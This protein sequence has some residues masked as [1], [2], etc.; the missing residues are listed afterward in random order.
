MQARGDNSPGYAGLC[1]VLWIMPT[2]SQKREKVR[3]LLGFENESN[4]LT[5]LD[6]TACHRHAA[7]CTDPTCW[8]PA[9]KKQV[10]QGTQ[11]GSAPKKATQKG[12]WG[13]RFVPQSSAIFIGSR[14]SFAVQIRN[15]EGR[16]RRCLSTADAFK[17]GSVSAT[18]VDL[19]TCQP[20]EVHGAYTPV[21]RAQP[22]RQPIRPGAVITLG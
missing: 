3:L 12:G 22:S 2:T 7:Q 6:W 21:S 10:D 8:L 17:T 4:L 5:N 15:E 20:T 16:L 11:G 9:V 13:L 14:L 1:L 19:A 18:I